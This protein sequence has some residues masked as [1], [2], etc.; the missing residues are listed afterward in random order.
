MNSPARKPILT[1]PSAAEDSSSFKTRLSIL[2]RDNRTH[3]YVDTSFLMWLTKIGSKS[4]QELLT[5][6]HAHCAGR[7]HVPIW[8]A[9]EYL[10]H[11]VAGTIVTELSEKN[12]EMARLVGRTYSYFRPFIDEAHGDGAED[13]STIRAATRSALTALDRLTSI[14]RQWQKSYQKH[15]SEVIGFINAN[16][17]EST[18]LYG[19]F[20][21]LPG[22]GAGRFVGS[23]PPGFQ[24]RR[25]K[26]GSQSV[27]S[28]RDEVP[29]DSN[30]FGDLVFWKEILDHAKA[31]QA[32]A[33]IILT[34]DR[35]NDW[36]LGGSNPAQI[37]PALLALKKSWKPVPRPHPMLVMEARL[38]A[39]V[40]EVELLDSPYLAALLRDVAEE[41]VRAFADVAIIPDGP[42]PESEVERRAKLIEDRRAADNARATA[43]ARENGFLFPDAPEVVASAAAFRRAL[44]E[45]RQ[46]VSERGRVLLDEWRA[47]V[48]AQQLI[49][50]SLTEVKLS[51]LDQKELVRIARELHDRVLRE[52]AGYVEAL[53]DLVSILEMLPPKTAAC[54]YLG[55]LASMFLE[56]DTNASRVPPR[57][58]V[59][60]QLF[61]RQSAPYALH[62]VSAVSRRLADNPVRPVYIPSSDPAPVEVS[63]DTAVN[64]PGLDEL[65]SLRVT[66]V[67]LLTAA[68]ADQELR[69]GALFDGANAVDGDKIVQKACEL[70]AI[71]VAQV[72]RTEA[73]ALVY[74]LTAT[75]GFKRP[76][77]IS[78][79]KEQALGG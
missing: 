40:E 30:R 74:S 36:H 28:E 44:L 37:D 73:F 3:I 32:R 76:V 57:S 17:P 77:D 69:L 19:Y 46:P 55:F 18:P 43:E 79:P 22:L 26:G 29:V 2:L 50:E 41:E 27:N 25:K 1:I 78:I 24:D 72:V 60:Q 47:T 61:E 64:T 51:G 68:Q 7:V 11:H 45:S 21:D 58:P 5:W 38:A 52:E 54:F 9:H 66:G 16:T 4:R 63:L 10:K 70:F 31:T 33:V 14:S 35:K 75:I 12:D 42:D 8:A 20:Q 65:R 6:L 59:A 67:E 62:A 53:A 48:E 71:P 49:R 39:A 23:I 34:N 15:A 13:A 56:R